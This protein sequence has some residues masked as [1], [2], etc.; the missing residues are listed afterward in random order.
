MSKVEEI[1]VGV[2]VGVGFG[3]V[4]VVGV[5]VGD[6]HIKYFFHL[7]QKNSIGVVVGSVFYSS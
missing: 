4:V 3:V 2:G 6:I 1:G 5:G 7:L